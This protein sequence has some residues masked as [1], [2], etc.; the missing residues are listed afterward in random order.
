VRTRNDRGRGE[1]CVEEQRQRSRRTKSWALRRIL[2]L[3]LLALACTGGDGEGSSKG[4]PLAI[5]P[6]VRDSAGITI[7]ENVEPQWAAGSEWRVGGLLTV[8]GEVPGDPA[9]ELFRARE[10]TR[11]SNGDVAVGNSSNGEIRLFRQDGS[12]I[13]T[14]GST[15]GGPGEFRGANAM[16]A[17]QRVPGDTLIAWDIYA[18]RVSVFAPDGEFVRSFGLAGP[19]QQHFFGGIFADRSL[20][21][22]V[23]ESSR[24]ESSGTLPEGLNRRN[25][26]LHHYGVDHSLSNS[27]RGIPGS[28]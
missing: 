9:H 13:R 1:E 26:S 4:T 17:L 11:Q 2:A 5:P 22:V 25:T 28:D 7:V 12:H 8:I 24:D 15:G 19:A 21:M 10:G 3:P 18:Q 14:V 20:Q 16:R 6:T 27:I 23:Y